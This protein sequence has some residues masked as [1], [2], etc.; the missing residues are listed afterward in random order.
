MD[1]SYDLSI[2]VDGLENENVR[3]SPNV[4]LILVEN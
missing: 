2:I 3:Y 1:S 4:L